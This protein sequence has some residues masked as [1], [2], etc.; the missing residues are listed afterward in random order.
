[1]SYI[2]DYRKEVDKMNPT[3][4]QFV[5]GYRSAMNDAMN[6]FD[7][8]DIYEVSDLKKKL[9]NESKAIFKDWMEMEET[10]AVLSIFESGDY[11]DIELKDANKPIFITKKGKKKH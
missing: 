5:A 11:D 3:D 10:V 9:V 4:R 7:N 2:P 8:I 6:F 1:M